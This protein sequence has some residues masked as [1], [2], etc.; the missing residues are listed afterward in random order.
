[1]QLRGFTLISLRGNSIGTDNLT[2]PDTL[3]SFNTTALLTIET[4]FETEFRELSRNFPGTFQDFYKGTVDFRHMS[5]Q[6]SRKCTN[7]YGGECS[8]V[9]F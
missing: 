9:F 3:K 8:E 4:F 1:M 5:V 6:V 7:F 2:G